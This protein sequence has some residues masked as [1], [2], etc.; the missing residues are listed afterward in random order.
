MCMCYAILLL[1][2]LCTTHNSL[3]IRKNTLSF[4]RTQNFDNDLYENAKA[5]LQEEV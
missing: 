3:K 4:L 5:N 1:V 2:W